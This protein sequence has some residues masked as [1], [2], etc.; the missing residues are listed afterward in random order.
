MLLREPV[1]GLPPHDVETAWDPAQKT[2]SRLGLALFED[3]TKDLGPWLGQRPFL[4]RGLGIC[5]SGFHE[6]LGG[7]PL[8][9]CQDV[10]DLMQDVK[11]G[12]R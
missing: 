9:A 3:A 1:Q 12:L 8:G 11:A 2:G 7:D 10:K 5:S 4:R 6:G